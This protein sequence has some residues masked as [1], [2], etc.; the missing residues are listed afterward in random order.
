MF[1]LDAALSGHLV[2]TVIEVLLVDAGYQVIPL[3]I[4]RVVRELRTADAQRYHQIAPPRLRSM[5]D[6]LVI[7]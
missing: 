4:E 7:E 2:A 3:G 5:P 1:P 6:F